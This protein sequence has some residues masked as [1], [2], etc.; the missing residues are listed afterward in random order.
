[1]GLGFA[2]VASFALA[3]SSAGAETAQLW[4]DASTWGGAVP[5]AGEVVR[6]PA[7][8][9]VV[10]DVSPPALRSI[11]VNGTLRFAD[12]DLTLRTG[13]IM[14]HGR[15][16]VGTE[17][18]PFTSKATIVLDGNDSDDVMGMGAHVLGVMGGTLDLHGAPR[19]VR[20]TRLSR[21]AFAGDRVITVAAA[22]GWRVGDR[23]AI[24][25]TGLDPSQA[26]ER[27][28]EARNGRLLTLDRALGNTHW[29]R[30]ETIA[31]KPVAQRAEVGL[32]SRN[33]VIRGPATGPTT[34]IGGH[35]MVHQ[36]SLARVSDVEFEGM[37]Q[38]GRMAR[39]PFHF[40][41]MGS[42]PGSYIRSSAIH[43]SF[44]R[45]VTVHGTSNVTVADNV[46]FRTRGHCFFLED[47]AE[48]GVKLLRNLGMSTMAPEASK[49]LL[50]TD[51]TP[52]TFWIQHP[53]NILRGNAA[54]GSEGNGF[55]YDL[56]ERPTG[57]SAT[58]SISPRTA[59]FGEFANN[60]AHTNVNR[61]NR[62]RSGSG[63]LVEDYRPPGPAM[64][65]HF[66]GYKN[67]GF[68]VWTEHGTT[69]RYATLAENN[70]SYL[71]RD[72]ALKRSI[73]V[74]TT[75]NNADAHWS[76]TGV[77]LYHDTADVRRVTFAN[78]KP[79]EWRHGV[80]I[81][82]IIED[83]TTV[84]RFSNV[85]FVNADRVRMTPPWITDRV[86]ATMITDADG[87][88]TGSGRS[89]TLVASHPLLV[90]RDCRRNA[91]L[92]LNVCP[93]GRRISMVRVQDQTGSTSKLGP[94]TIRR[95][96]G[97]RARIPADPDWADNP[98]AQGTVLMGRRYT[99]KLGR[100]T[101]RN[102]EWVTSNAQ[103]GSV[104]LGVSWPHDSV[105]VYRGWGEWALT[106]RRA[107]SRSQL[108][109]GDRYWVD[110]SGRVHVRFNSD[111]DWTWDRI[112]VCSRRYC[113]EGL[114]TQNIFEY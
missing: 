111:G 26:E 2:V 22:D 14:V 113:G 90:D 70:V 61:A 94:V 42:A 58:D 71:G 79:R 18:N 28:I 77:G 32:L 8:K 99:V 67:T 68:G 66:T 45:C 91:T 64:F 27:T 52:A 51:A 19:P 105:H 84:P 40:H 17:T 24:A 23:I 5:V 50:D 87:S 11:E 100:Q 78:F 7:G 92:D 97:A 98:Q 72:S 76:T 30:T 102:L 1:M 80:G 60:V 101:P 16:Q 3:P 46:A 85:R 15:L 38:A 20:W 6:I 74:G 55:W 89:R 39:Y 95:S 107:N 33:L 65:D 9:T 41:M 69:T 31:G 25:A 106:L 112:K 56:P 47:G 37:G 109:D 10:L 93:A 62:F 57:L 4:S 53:N 35:V 13:S 36:G 48:R 54:A 81:G 21:T 104:Q 44:S 86:A 43:D 34:G 108:A 83:I 96:D 12:R 59:P 73:V 110:G 114:G 29:G 88:V 75:S 63:L 49:R 82:P 103:R